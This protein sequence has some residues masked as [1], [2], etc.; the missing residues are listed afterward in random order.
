MDET[1]SKKITPKHAKDNV[2]TMN[3]QTVSKAYI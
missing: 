2:I 3:Q 1:I